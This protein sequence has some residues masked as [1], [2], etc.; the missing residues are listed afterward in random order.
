MGYPRAGVPG[1]GSREPGRAYDTSREVRV[2]WRNERPLSAAAKLIGFLLLLIAIF[3]G[4]RAVGAQLG[5]VSTSQSQ[6]QSPSGGGGGSM[7]M[8]GQP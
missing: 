5:P 8:G 7:H 2:T 6:I 3:L 4:A 1:P